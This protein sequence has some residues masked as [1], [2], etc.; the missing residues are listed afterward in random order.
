V[1]DNHMQQKGRPMPDILPPQGVMFHCLSLKSSD[2]AF[3][4]SNTQPNIAS[5]LQGLS[6]LFEEYRRTI[7]RPASSSEQLLKSAMLVALF[8]SRAEN[9]HC[10][11]L[12]CSLLVRFCQGGNTPSA[13]DCRFVSQQWNSTLERNIARQFLDAVFCMIEEE[14]DVYRDVVQLETWARISDIRSLPKDMPKTFRSPSPEQIAGTERETRFGHNP[15][16]EQPSQV[17]SRICFGKPPDDTDENGLFVS[18][19]ITRTEDNMDGHAARELRQLRPFALH[20]ESNDLSAISSGSP[21]ASDLYEYRSPMHAKLTER[22]RKLT[23]WLKQ[24]S[25]D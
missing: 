24:S 5:I 21:S 12:D 6:P 4:Q 15:A 16:A 22:I 9:L 13:H 20:S 17:P 3:V 11:M 10:A 1:N 14:S 19:C 7:R 18:L 23:G 25:T 2:G 8:S